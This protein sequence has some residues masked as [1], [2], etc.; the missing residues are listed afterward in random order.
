MKW[1]L[2]CGAS[3]DIGQ[4]IA[5][6][7][8]ANGWSLYLHY[9]RATAKIMTLVAELAKTYPKQDFIT[10]SQD[11]TELESAQQIAKQVFTTLDAV[12]F[13]QGT[14]EY[15]LFRELQPT[16]FDQML[17][18]QLQTPLRLVALL[19]DKLVQSKA[20]RIIFIGSVYGGNGSALE[21]GYSTLK[22]ALSAFCSAYS[23]EVAS[24]GL[25]VNVI[26]PGAV[27]TQMN[28]TFSAAEKAD[29]AEMIPKGRFADPKE[30]S[31]FV[32]SLLPKEAGYLTGQT[33]YVTGGWLR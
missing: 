1:A 3:G 4:Q 12:I 20:G 17:A 11:M 8:A 16:K 18:M 23:K 26:A 31:Y 13:A 29:V 28:L 21:V 5:I 7:L 19:E 2:I 32:K 6:D 25:T 27:Q 15:G 9:H 22:G 33:L 24:T 10:F 14:T 30:I